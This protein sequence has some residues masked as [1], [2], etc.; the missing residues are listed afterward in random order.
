[1]AASITSR[2]TS[3]A[4]GRRDRRVPDEP[5]AQQDRSA[6]GGH[7]H[8]H[9]AAQSREGRHQQVTGHGVAARR[10]H[11]GQ[12]P[13]GRGSRWPRR[14][15]GSG[16][17]TAP[18]PAPATTAIPS[19]IRPGARWP[20]WSRAANRART[21]S[22]QAVNFM[23]ETTP[24]S[25][26][27]HRD[28]VA[29]PAPWPTAARPRSACRRRRSPAAGR[30][31]VGRSGFRSVR[32]WLSRW[33]RHRPSAAATT[34]ET[35]PGAE[36]DRASAQIGSGRAAQLGGLEHR[37]QAAGTGKT[38]RSSA[39]PGTAEITRPCA[40]P[41]RGTNSLTVGQPVGP[42]LDRRCRPP[43]CP[44]PAGLPPRRVLTTSQCERQ[45]AWPRRART[46]RRCG[47]HRQRRRTD[48]AGPVSAR[49]RAA[50]A[51]RHPGLVSRPSNTE[52]PMAAQRQGP[53]AICPQDPVEGRSPRRRAR[54]LIRRRGPFEA[55]VEEGITPSGPHVASPDARP[56]SEV[57]DYGSPAA[58]H[59]RDG[60]PR[61]FVQC[62]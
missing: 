8:R 59:G 3:E 6:Q 17:R 40:R 26:P 7:R 35:S 1:M 41:P 13:A 58:R 21:A 20:S 50:L 62:T 38:T 28:V 12:I 47:R 49:W 52:M 51:G 23:A 34:S 4:S 32:I 42:R 43:R 31:W 22:G 15:A 5:V 30:R 45:P 19:T 25:S 9:H 11:P 53:S 2:P 16:G 18:R 60:D 61:R 33:P 37:H 54:S 10:S 57:T 27:L 14:R 56:D 55:A 29:G 46:P 44:W 36:E 24:R 39:R 48:C